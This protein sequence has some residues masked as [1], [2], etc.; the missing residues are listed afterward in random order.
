MEKPMKIK[1]FSP[2]LL[3]LLVACAGP[4]PNPGERTADVLWAKYE[5]NEALEIIKPQAEAGVPWAEL[6]LGVAYDL[7]RGVEQ[8]SIEAIKWYKRAAVQQA[9]GEWADGLL[10][11]ATGKAGYFNQ[12][13]DAMVAQ[14]QIANIYYQGKGNFPKDISKAYLWARYVFE[15]SAGKDVFFCCEF[16]GG[17]WILQKHIKETL[18]NIESEMTPEQKEKAD[19]IFFTWV[20]TAN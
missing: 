2:I 12:N 18:D 19:N 20:P 9:D 8:N 14:H 16:E 13:S 5:H 3:I 11:G 6:R 1:M 15:S 10:V 7:G 17:R 4:N